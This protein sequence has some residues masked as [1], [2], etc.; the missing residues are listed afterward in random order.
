MS[1]SSQ[2]HPKWNYSRQINKPAESGHSN[3]SL[4]EII[5]ET[6]TQSVVNT[7]YTLNMAL[8]NGN[9]ISKA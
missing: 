4:Q 5:D 6:V 8:T 9:L 3:L 2:K 7:C 1:L